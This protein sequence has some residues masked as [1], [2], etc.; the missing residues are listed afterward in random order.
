MKTLEPLDVLRD[1]LIGESFGWLSIGDSYSV[2]LTNDLFLVFQTAECSRGEQVKAALSDN[3]IG[4]L[5]G[6]DACDIP[7]TVSLL[8][9]RRRQ[10]TAVDL[11]PDGS[12]T[13]S[14]DR[15]WQLRILTTADMVDWQWT[16]NRTGVDPYTDSLVTCFLRDEVVVSPELANSR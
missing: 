6:V 2:A 7:L 15:A 9:N 16:L 3:T 1:L 11:A 5:D 12:L 8:R 10:I 4:L 13:L 14:F